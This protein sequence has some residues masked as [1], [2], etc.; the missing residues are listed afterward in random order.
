MKQNRPISFILASTHHGSM[1]VNRNDYHQTSTGSYGVGYQILATSSFDQSEVKLALRLIQKRRKYHNEGVVALDCGAN[2]GVHTLE[3]AKSMTGWGEVYAFE[4]QEKVF[5][6]LAGNIA[7]NN[8]FNVTAKNVALGAEK[9]MVAV[10]QPNYHQPASFG[11]LEIRQSETNEYIGQDINYTNT[12]DIEIIS[13]DSLNLERVDFVKI[14][15]E[16]MEEEVLKGAQ[17]T[18]K[19]QTPILLVEHIKSDKEFLK[20]FFGAL[21]YKIFP[22]G[23]NVLA[24][25]STDPI[26][27]DVRVEDG[28]FTLD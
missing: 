17:E 16:G 6:A 5:Y 28:I 11:S 3:W 14:D 26:L 10:P 18:I 15:V 12:K 23:L 25:H 8:C 2:I 20:S 19:T 1:I 22:L 24:I 9:G 13:I 7:L 27:Q 21:E 4:V